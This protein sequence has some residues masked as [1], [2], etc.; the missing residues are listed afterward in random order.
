MAGAYIYQPSFGG[1]VLGPALQ[2]RIDLQKFSVGLKTGKNVFIRPFGG[3][4]NR[5]GTRYVGPVSNHAVRH[6]LIPFERDED[7][8]YALVF[9]EKNMRVVQ[10]GTVLGAPY[11]LTTPFTA[12]D[13]QD[14]NYTQSID[15]M[16][17]AHASYAPRKL[18]H[19]G[20]TDWAF[21]DFDLTPEIGSPTITTV[22]AGEGI[23]VYSYKV[24][25]V[26][27]G[28]EGIP[29]AAFTKTNA[30]DLSLENSQNGI[31][32]TAVAGADEFRVYRQRGGVFGY[33][34]FVPGTQRVFY[35]DNIDPDTTS[36]PRQAS[37]LFSGAGNYPSV[38]SI[39]QQRLIWGASTNEPET[40]WASIIGSYED[41]T[42]GQVLAADDRFVMDISGE[43]LNRIKALVGLQE[44]MVFTGSGE[45]GVGSTDGSLSA[46]APRQQRYGASGTSGIRPLMVG[47]SILY[48]DKSGAQVRDLRYSYEVDGYSGNDLT[49]FVP[50]YFE[51]REVVDWCYCHSPHGIVW[52]VLDD[53]HLLSLTY[54]REQEVW[55]WTEHDLGGAVES[56]CSVVE[57]SEDALYL[58][59]RRET[60]A[61]TRR[62]IERMAERNIT[63]DVMDGCF[64]DCALSYGGVPTRIL[65]GLDHL[66]GM[67]VSALADGDVFTGLTVVNGAVTLPV[68]V[69]RAHV[70]ISYES[71]AETLPIS[72][73][74]QGT[75]NT[76]GLLHKATEVFVQME[77]TRG[78][79]LFSNS[80]DRG[81]EQSSQSGDMA[82]QLE[83]FTGISRFQ[84]RPNWSADG[85][86]RV[87]QRNP[88]PMAIL[89]LSP[90]WLAGRG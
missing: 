8:T 30:R 58:I 48:V 27:D 64:L 34:G 51:G 67:N 3:F 36:T 61:G 69:S 78:I 57:G 23:R 53:G 44:L 35:D 80:A 24:S 38:V 21:A 39:A 85:T 71:V 18:E 10:D 54:K 79:E 33:I 70:G 59:V 84:L 66:E 28:V 55:A 56:V 62:Y 50:N 1:G 89:A 45:Y 43:K 60:P 14:L 65:S 12:A 41:F 5:A 47:D 22:T 86:I 25:A 68:S 26:V 17:T 4:S 2:G 7:Q 49:V 77:K 29:S 37:G 63:S 73:E 81:T 16:F 72:I 9:G 40:I 83:M 19:R 76:R 90:K 15:V 52:V 87:V 88:L 46:V 42:R 82:D 31:E 75:G 13:V 74:M 11:T 32:W 6:R 20:A